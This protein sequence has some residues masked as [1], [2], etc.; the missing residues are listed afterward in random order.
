MDMPE[1]LTR[2]TGR[3]LELQPFLDHL[4]ARYLA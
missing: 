2:A 1:L 3:P 4:R